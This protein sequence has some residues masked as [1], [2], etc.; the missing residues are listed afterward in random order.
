MQIDQEFLAL[1]WKMQEMYTDL[2]YGRKVCIHEAAHALYLEKGGREVSFYGPAILYE[3][4]TNKYHSIGAMV[5]GGY[6]WMPNT[7][8]LLFEHAKQLVAGGVAVRKFLNVDEAG[9]ETDHRQ[10]IAMCGHLPIVLQKLNLNPEE[11]WAGAQEAVNRE[12]EN[13]EFKEQ[14]MF[15]THKDLEKLYRL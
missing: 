14:L 12:L 5:D 7:K 2:N 9:D 10:F 4:R 8:E 11:I 1:Y 3:N 15:K 13:E 6:D